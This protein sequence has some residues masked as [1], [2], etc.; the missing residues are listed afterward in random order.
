VSNRYAMTDSPERV[1]LSPQCEESQ[2]PGRTWCAVDQGPCDDCAS[3]S[4]EYVRADVALSRSPQPVEGVEVTEALEERLQFRINHATLSLNNP[5]WRPTRAYVE[6]VRNEMRDALSA[7]RAS[8]PMGWQTFDTAPRDGTKFDVWY[9]EHFGQPAQRMVGV[10]WS[11]AEDWFCTDGR[12]GPD[13]PQPIA[14]FP[15]PSH[16]QPLP[17][18]PSPVDEGRGR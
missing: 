14:S 11:T 12:Y 16:W 3:P 8:P 17:A 10:Y 18:P 15:H 5:D 2:D 7:L 6:G 4:V 13:E 9:P 1:W